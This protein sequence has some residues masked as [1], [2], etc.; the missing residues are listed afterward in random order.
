MTAM[1][2]FSERRAIMRSSFVALVVC[3]SLMIC[4]AA[5][6]DRP[7]RVTAASSPEQLRRYLVTDGQLWSV[8][9]SSAIEVGSDRQLGLPQGLASN[10]IEGVWRDGSNKTYVT[11]VV[12]G[13]PFLFV[14]AGRSWVRRIIV[15]RWPKAWKAIVG[16]PEHVTF[17][18]ARNKRPVLVETTRLTATQQATSVYQVSPADG[19]VTEQG[20]DVWDDIGQTAWLNGMVGAAIVGPA[21][22]FLGYTEDGGSTWALSSFDGFGSDGDTLTF[23]GL[24]ATSTG[25]AVTAATINTD[26]SESVFEVASSNAGRSFETSSQSAVLPASDNPSDVFA[27]SDGNAVWVVPGYGHTVYRLDAGGTTW[28]MTV[29]GDSLPQGVIDLSYDSGVLTAVIANS[30]CTGYKTGCSTTV[31][32]VSSSD[33]GSSWNPA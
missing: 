30:S 9:G 7:E 8:G 4:L 18:G 20:S 32:A 13:Q 10:Y 22:Q 17:V 29:P 3:A 25:F 19:T 23:N 31:S 12:R 16:A 11:S 21:H 33:G 2:T 24:E 15:T 6:A 14:K 26:G 1:A 28:Q 27:A 5:C